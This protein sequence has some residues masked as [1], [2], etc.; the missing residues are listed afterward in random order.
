MATASIEEESLDLSTCS[1]CLEPYNQ[2]LRKP[3]FIPCAH[4][5]CLNYIKVFI[6][7]SDFSFLFILWLIWGIFICLWYIRLFKGMA[8]AMTDREVEIAQLISLYSHCVGIKRL[9]TACAILRQLH[10]WPLAERVSFLAEIAVILLFLVCS[11]IKRIQW[12]VSS[13]VCHKL[14]SRKTRN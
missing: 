1:V 11:Q 12:S 8:P 7:L 14:L 5:Y 2:E 13:P 6:H 9:S 10:L 4:I 3:K